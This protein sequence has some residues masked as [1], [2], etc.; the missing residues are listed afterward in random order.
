MIMSIKRVTLFLMLLL[1]PIL[2]FAQK[3]SIL[4]RI[5]KKGELRVGTSASQP[6]YSVKA[7]DG[8]LMG[9]DIDLAELISEAMNV[10]LNFVVKPF[11]EL[12][13]ALEKGEVDIVMSGMTITP[14]RNAKVAF[15]GP[16]IVSGRSILAKGKRLA[17]LD[18]M[19]EINKP[20]IHAV[21]L[22]G[23]ISQRFVENLTPQI[24]LTTVKDYESGVNMVLQDKVDLMVADYSICQL[25]LLRHPDADLATLEVPLTIEPVGIA[26]PA[27]GFLLH[28]LIENHLTALQMTGVLDDLEHK[29]FKD[30]SW[31]IRLP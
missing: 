2:L 31:L 14:E 11:P 24:K 17:E 28:N 25:S 13:P 16:Y 8:K 5:L 3:E 20:T 1:F 10:K 6:P 7:K 9:Y 26:L 4:G 21:A 12:L 29:W 15:A 30:G 27:E 18:E 22:E 19:E 23:S